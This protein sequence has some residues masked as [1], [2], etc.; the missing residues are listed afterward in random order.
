MSTHSFTRGIIA[1][2]GPAGSG[3][4]SA[5]A[6]LAR[7]L[8]GVLLDTGALYRSLA[9]LARQRG[10]SWDDEAG[11]AALAADLPVRF[12]GDASPQRVRLDDADV[13]ADIRTPEMS[14]GA[15]RVSR[16]PAVRQALLG[17]QRRLGATGVVVAEGRDMG[18]VVFPDAP[19]KFFLTADAEA[20][21]QRRW[22]ELRDRGIERT[23]EEVLAEQRERDRRDASREAAP[24]VQAA[25]AVL[26]D[27]SGL[28][29][30][31]VVDRMLA[32]VTARS[33]AGLP[34][35]AK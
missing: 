18:S 28:T 32:T 19:V 16:H 33:T 2:D 27:S 9:L 31:Q 5:A 1:V 11:L 15:S 7:C 4:S 29:L 20:R 13:T 3:K 12:E 35:P 22:L 17:L 21:A 24:L 10:V 30:E 26:L 23:F 6:A 14:D 25:D 34:T 8:G